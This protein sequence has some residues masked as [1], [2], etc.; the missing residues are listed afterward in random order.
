MKKVLIASLLIL[1][2]C[3]SLFACSSKKGGDPAVEAEL[4]KYD[5]TEKDL[6]IN[7]KDYI[8]FDEEHDLILHSTASDKEVSKAAYD[9]CKKVADD[10]VVLD[11]ISEEPMEYS[12]DADG[13]GIIHFSYTRDGEFKTLW[14]TSYWEEDGYTEYVISVD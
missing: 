3:L 13:D 2:L 6:A 7:E 1:A 4:S 10:G 14:V 5:F 11:Y 8:E 12:Y 9:A